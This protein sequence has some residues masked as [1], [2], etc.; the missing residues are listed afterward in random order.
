[1]G[2]K[3]RI[4]K[5]VVK[6]FLDETPGVLKNYKDVYNS[7]Y[8]NLQDS[9]DGSPTRVL[10]INQFRECLQKS[11]DSFKQDNVQGC[12]ITLNMD[13]HK[14]QFDLLY[15]FGFRFHNASGSEVTLVKFVPEKG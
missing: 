11:L 5:H 7:R 14:P 8:I 1:M 6:H 12:F 13:S 9:I 15:N 4:G 10:E 2:P 3:N